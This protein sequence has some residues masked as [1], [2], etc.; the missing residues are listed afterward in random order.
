SLAGRGRH[1]QCGAHRCPRKRGGRAR[2]RPGKGVWCHPRHEIQR[3]GGSALDLAGALGKSGRGTGCQR[4]GL[5]GQSTLARARAYAACR[6]EHVTMATTA[7]PYTHEGVYA[8]LERPRTVRRISWGAVVAGV[9][10]VLVVQMALM[11]LG[12]AIGTATIDPAA[13]STPQAST[14]G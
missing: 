7:R 8:D 10:V 6:L 14:L 9:V 11:L 4:H 12:L 5:V 2:H 13:A 1:P 3:R